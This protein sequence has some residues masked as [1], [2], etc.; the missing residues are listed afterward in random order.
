MP[1]TWG[2][3]TTNGYM[4]RSTRRQHNVMA[5]LDRWLAEDDSHAVAYNYLV[6]QVE[7]G[8][9]SQFYRDLLDKAL[10]YGNLTP[11]QLAA[12]LR[13]IERDTERA[14][15]RAAEL[16]GVEPLPEGRRTVTGEIV[17]CKWRDGQ[18]PGFK[19]VVREATGNRVWGT[20][21]T[22]LDPELNPRLNDE[23]IDSY[24]GLVGRTVT[25]TATVT[26][27]DDDEHFGFF[28]RPAGAVYVSAE[29]VPTVQLPRSTATLL[30]EDEG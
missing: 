29:P 4:P 24:E 10:R 13:S 21:A 5:A 1:R 23:G 25:M 19:I 16:K 12:V 15:E 7:A 3:G 26:R 17:S 27:S 8:A 22:S 20:L 18:F 6:A 28:K 11:N 9:R 30:V 2:Y 14:A